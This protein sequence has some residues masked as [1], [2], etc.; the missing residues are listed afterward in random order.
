M[1]VLEPGDRG[2]LCG[3]TRAVSDLAVLFP[4]APY[5]QRWVRSA[6]N[7]AGGWQI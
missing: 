1:L 3:E 5:R 6:G 2:G 4:S 7:G